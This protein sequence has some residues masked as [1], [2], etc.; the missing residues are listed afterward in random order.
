[1]DNK[2]LTKADVLRTA[3]EDNVVYKYFE[4]LKG[5]LPIRPLSDG[6][7]QEIEVKQ[8][9]NLDIDIS[10]LK[11]LEGAS[12]EQILK[13][14][15]MDVDLGEFLG[16]DYEANCLACKFGLAFDESLTV[17]EVKELRPPGIVEDI[18]NKI[19]ELSGMEGSGVEDALESFRTNK[20]S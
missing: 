9:S 14:L 19:F 1:M 3:S 11:N 7:A 8:L 6:E 12:K 2:K 18:A 17:E 4:K 16:D 20:E 5:E 13:K 15:D 10:N